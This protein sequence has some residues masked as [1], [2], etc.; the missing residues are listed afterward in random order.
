MEPS[1]DNTWLLELLPPAEYKSHHP[2]RGL[3]ADCLDDLNPE[4]KFLLEAWAWEGL[5]LSQLSTRMGFGGK[6]TAHYRLNRALRALR[7][8]LKERGLDYDEPDTSG[9]TTEAD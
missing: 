2:L 9:D 3:F 7:Q 4:D 1:K 6:Q 5:T 8:A